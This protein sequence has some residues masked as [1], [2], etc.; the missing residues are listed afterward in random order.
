[1]RVRLDVS[2]GCPR[3]RFYALGFF[4]AFAVLMTIFLVIDPGRGNAP[5]IWRNL[6]ASPIA[7]ASFVGTFAL[8]LAIPVALFFLNWRYMSAAYPSDET[9]ECDSS[10][11]TLSRVSWFDVSNTHWTTR[12]YPTRDIRDVKYRA[13]G[14]AKGASIYGLR[15]FAGG[16]KQRVLPG[17]PL[18]DAETVMHA[19][20]LLGVDVPDDPEFA[21]KIAAD[22]SVTGRSL[23][24]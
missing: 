9:F 15:F 12:S 22:T 23:S 16:V 3:T 4:V 8:V 6:S 17:L 5:S 19:L 7:S 24:S 21:R 11:L 1:M 20:K 10:T 13:L 14:S 2:T 18:R